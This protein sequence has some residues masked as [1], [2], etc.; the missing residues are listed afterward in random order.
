MADTLGTERCRAT[1]DALVEKNPHDGVKLAARFS[2]AELVLSDKG[3]TEAQRAAAAEDLKTVVDG[4][5]DEDTVAR[6][7]SALLE[8]EP[9]SSGA[10]G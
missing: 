10:G 8:L 1:L 3:A 4:S 7:K 6:A 5:D 9:E 2:R